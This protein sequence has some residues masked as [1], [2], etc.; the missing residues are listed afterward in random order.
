MENTRE[1][2]EYVLELVAEALA[3][4]PGREYELAKQDFEEIFQRFRFSSSLDGQAT[5]AGPGGVICEFLQGHPLLLPDVAFT[6]FDVIMDYVN[7]Q[8]RHTDGVKQHRPLTAVEWQECYELFDLLD[9]VNGFFEFD[10]GR[11]SKGPKER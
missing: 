4:K 8:L 9:A 2:S 7:D 1:A 6:L 3:K 10:K 11:L 5:G